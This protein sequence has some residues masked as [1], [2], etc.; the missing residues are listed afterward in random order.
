MALAP[1][2]QDFVLSIEGRE[3]PEPAALALFGLGLVG[4]GATR[5]RKAA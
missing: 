1:G 3:V 4:L 2:S 5:R